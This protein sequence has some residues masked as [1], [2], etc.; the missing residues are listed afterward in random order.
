M[1]KSNI[2]INLLNKNIINIKNSLY[3]LAPSVLELL[4]SLVTFPIFS[5]NLSPYDFSVIGYYESINQIFLPIM[6]LSFYV[7]YMKDFFKR[8][9]EEN[10]RVLISLMLFL[11]GTNLLIISLGFVLLHVYFKL[12]QVTFPI[13]PYALLSLSSL[14]FTLYGSFLGIEYKMNR[15][16]LKFFLLMS[17]SALLALS[18]SL[19]LVVNLDFGAMG[20]MSGIVISQLAIGV[21]AFKV[22]YKKVDFD[23]NIIKKAL[24]FGYPL[25]IIAFLDF[26]TVYID[27]IILER[28]NDIAN[29]ALYSIGLK[30]AGFV[31]MLG[32][33]VYQAFE[34]DFYK[35]ASQKNIGRFIQSVLL[36]FGFLFGVN[37]VF[38]FISKPVVEF[39]TSGRY[40]GAYQYANLIIWSNF[41]LLLSYLL[42][43]ILIV[44]NKTKIL[45][46]RKI[47][48]AFFGVTMFVLLISRWQFIGAA[49]ARIIINSLNCFILIIFII[50][51]SDTIKNLIKNHFKKFLNKIDNG[52]IGE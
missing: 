27:R 34:P 2:V 21:F 20:R 5:R 35:F 52:K 25:I 49:Y 1:I 32:S 4:I 19:F 42:G 33:S 40:T 46:Y 12:A 28:Q 9:P 24:R 23:F 13:F 48:M 36:V 15:E 8:T 7:Y 43:V 31:F 44:Q 16:G 29:F 14:Y 26:P 18:V 22:L 30:M 41:F 47:I 51:S 37:I 50:G 11:S 6:N 3:F 10:K 38:T 39:L 45:L 17:I